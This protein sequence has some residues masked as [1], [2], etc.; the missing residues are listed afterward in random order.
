MLEHRKFEKVETSWALDLFSCW[1]VVTKNIKESWKNVDPGGM[2]MTIV[3][4]KTLRYTNLCHFFVLQVYS[5]PASAV[6]VL[7][8]PE[9]ACL[10]VL[11]KK[12]INIFVHRKKESERNASVS[13]LFPSPSL[14]ASLFLSRTHVHTSRL[15][16]SASRRVGS[17]RVELPARTQTQ[18]RHQQT[19]FFFSWERNIL[20]L[21]CAYVRPI[22]HCDTRVCVLEAAK[23]ACTY[24]HR[25]TNTTI[26]CV[27]RLEIC[28]VAFR[29]RWNKKISGFRSR[30]TTGKIL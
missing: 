21:P 5:H 20:E 28:V 2:W 23:R 25:S 9:C 30:S 17:K 22:S 19:T 10:C 18:T 3:H 4:P 26:F 15:I 7:S 11:Q 1:S 6:T 29:H 13:F 8:G 27:N 14:F 16:F 12:K 24:F